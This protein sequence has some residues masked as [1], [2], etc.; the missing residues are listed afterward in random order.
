M[1]IGTLSILLHAALAA[2]PV[3]VADPVV[4]TSTLESWVGPSTVPVGGD[5]LARYFNGGYRLS[6]SRHFL[7]VHAGDNDSA[8]ALVDLL[9]DGRARFF[10]LFGAAG[11]A[12]HDFDQPLLW[13]L[14]DTHAQLDRM[15]FET[16]RRDL[17]WLDAYYSPRTNRVALVRLQAAAPVA[18]QEGVA[19]LASARPQ[20]CTTPV[21]G[22]DVARV[23]HELAHQL[24]FNSGVM[25]RGVAYP[26]WVAEGLADH[27]AGV[28]SLCANRRSLLA[29][30]QRAAV[31]AGRPRPR[32]PL[33]ELV[34]L[35]SVPDDD[36]ALANTIYDEAES[37]FGFLLTARR[38]ALLAFLTRVAISG[39]GIPTR[40]ECEAQFD[41]A[42]G[43]ID[44]LETAW[45]ASTTPSTL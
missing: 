24:A 12:L 4:A 22:V 20:V 16:E 6:T 37:L 14:F 36:P 11:F 1:A 38:V 43:D 32:L 25:E 33:R 44:A 13:E 2:G 28:V 26:V 39:P 21:V 17:S 9:E 27:F 23:V 15:S 45:V 10:K 7:M 34:G 31:T 29:S 19:F 5:E 40:R 3:V 18:D 42:F 35:R 41:A 30:D 8:A